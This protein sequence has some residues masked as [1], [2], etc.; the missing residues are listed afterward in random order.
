MKKH[1]Q[2][3][4]EPRNPL[5]NPTQLDDLEL[6]R[7]QAAVARRDLANDRAQ[8]AAQ[9]VDLLVAQAMQ[10]RGL[11]RATINTETGAIGPVAGEAPKVAP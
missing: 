9:V 11:A 3:Q 6:A 1:K 2:P 8:H 10:R 4:P 7:I 5:V